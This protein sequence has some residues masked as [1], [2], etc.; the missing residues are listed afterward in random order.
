V[1]TLGWALVQVKPHSTEQLDEQPSPFTVSPSSHDSSLS[2]PG[3]P[4]AV[5]PSPHTGAGVGVVVVAIGMG[6][7]VVCTMIIGDR[8]IPVWH[9]L[10]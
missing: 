1:Q 10:L 2:Y 8:M 6:V 3:T 4:T 9:V 7:A 5:F